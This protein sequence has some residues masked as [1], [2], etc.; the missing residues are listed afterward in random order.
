VQRFM[1]VQPDRRLCGNAAHGRK[2][3]PVVSRSPS[4]VRVI[5]TIARLHRF[6]TASA[7][8]QHPDWPRRIR[9]R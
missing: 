8:I 5:I 4:H 1:N 2:L 7:P 3:A 9:H 6:A